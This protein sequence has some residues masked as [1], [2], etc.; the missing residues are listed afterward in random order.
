MKGIEEYDDDSLQFMINEYVLQS[1]IY[2]TFANDLKV[3]IRQ[4]TIFK[5]LRPYL[6]TGTLAYLFPEIDDMF[7]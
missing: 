7:G 4:H 3:E 5:K 6:T 2:S 1:L